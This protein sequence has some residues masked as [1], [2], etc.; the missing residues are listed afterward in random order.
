MKIANDGLIYVLRSQSMT[1]CRCSARTAP[2]GR[3]SGSICRNAERL[4]HRM[5]VS[6]PDREQSFL[7]M[8]DGGNNQSVVRRSDGEVVGTY[9]ALLAAL[10][11]S[12]SGCITSHSTR[13]AMSSPLRCAKASA[14]SAGR[15]RAA[16]RSARCSSEVREC[17]A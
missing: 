4:G 7:I 5:W 8:V 12:S 1:V 3:A 10:P 11:T 17:I 2:S 14:F 16:R 6:W 15:S 9:G 13:A